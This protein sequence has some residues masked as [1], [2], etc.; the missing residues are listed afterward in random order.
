MEP[1]RSESNISCGI[2]LDFIVSYEDVDKQQVMLI[3][4]TLMDYVKREYTGELGNDQES[5]EPSCT[6]K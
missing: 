3:R 2:P 4:S 5:V 6:Y 1:T